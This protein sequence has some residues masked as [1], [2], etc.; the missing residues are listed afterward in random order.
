MASTANSSSELVGQQ[1]RAIE[2]T[3][4][5]LA[6]TAP[7]ETLALPD[8]T[9]EATP[10]SPSTTPQPGPSL[11]PIPPMKRKQTSP[12]EQSST[13]F[14]KVLAMAFQ[15]IVIHANSPYHID[16]LPPFLQTFYRSP[17]VQ[18]LP[19][20]TQA[21]FIKILDHVAL[22][23]KVAYDLSDKVQ[24]QS[25]HI[26]KC[27]TLLRKNWIRVPT[28]DACLCRD[29]GELG[30]DPDL[31]EDVVADVLVYPGDDGQGQ[32]MCRFCGGVGTHGWEGWEADARLQK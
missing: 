25:G 14:H 15:T 18:N 28:E 3:T 22:A 13:N 21:T 5:G 23:T 24:E 11:Q 12:Q 7:P 31:D 20:S 1:D 32:F 29:C 8:R 17:N 16:K 4:A 27:E 2:A 30:F 19:P 6:S 9:I 26:H 10:S